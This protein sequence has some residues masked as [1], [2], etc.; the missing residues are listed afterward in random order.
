MLESSS[1]KKFLNILIIDDEPFILDILSHYL[2]NQG[3]NVQI[4]SNEIDAI[5]YMQDSNFDL[6]LTDVFMKSGSFSN[7]LDNVKNPDS[8]FKDIPIIA[9]TGQPNYI[10]S[11][12]KSKLKGVLEKPFTP[13]ELIEFI[14]TTL[15]GKLP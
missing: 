2:A 9:V 5:R 1:E 15:S 6:I 4:A 11:K 14:Q 7:L 10:T 8:K 12:Q 13:D 3:F